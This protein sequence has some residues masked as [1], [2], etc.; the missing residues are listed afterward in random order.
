MFGGDQ[1]YDWVLLLIWM[2]TF[3]LRLCVG[4]ELG[5]SSLSHHE[6]TNFVWNFLHCYDYLSLAFPVLF[7]DSQNLAL[8]LTHTGHLWL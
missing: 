3:V 1:I 6:V 8:G 2:S 4:S 7:L 5:K